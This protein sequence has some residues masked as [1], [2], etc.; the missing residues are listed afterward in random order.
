MLPSHIQT[1]IQSLGQVQHLGIAEGL[2]L[3][4]H[5]NSILVSLESKPLGTRALPHYGTP[6]RGLFFSLALCWVLSADCCPQLWF[7]PDFRALCGW[8]EFRFINTA[9]ILISF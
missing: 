2:A 5:V 9:K 4:S 3:G 8:Y 1:H 6:Q 7:P